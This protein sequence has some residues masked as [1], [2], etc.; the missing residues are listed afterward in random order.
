MFMKKLS[1]VMLVM[2]LFLIPM[3]AIGAGEKQETFSPYVDGKGNINVPSDF[4]EKWVHLGTWV[5]TSEAAAGPSLGPT[6]P[7]TGIH[8]VYTQPESVMVYKKTG[9]WPDGAVLVM[10]ACSIKWDDLPTGHVILA[11]EILDR[12]VMVKD[13]K[14]RFKNNPNWGEGWGWA[15]FNAAN[16]KKNISTNCKNDCIGCHEVAKNTDWVF[17]HGYPTLK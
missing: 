15:L 10:E 17:V 4:R 14:D 3:I 5:V 12:F 11:G 2:T 1:K 6:A 16:P 9:K 7:G 8:E 13:S